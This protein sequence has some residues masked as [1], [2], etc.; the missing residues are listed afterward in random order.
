M[1]IGITAG[2]ISLVTFPIEF[3]LKPYVMLE[4]Q[5][6]S[7]CMN[8]PISYKTFWGVD[9]ALQ[10]HKIRLNYYISSSEFTLGGLL[11][12]PKQ[13]TYYKLLSKTPFEC[14]F[15]QG[16]ISETLTEISTL[17]LK[18]FIGGNQ[19]PSS[20]QYRLRFEGEQS[21]IETSLE[22]YAM[23]IFPGE[24]LLSFSIG[25]VPL[26][27]QTISIQAR[28][29][30]ELTLELGN[31]FAK[32]TIDVTLMGTTPN[33][34][35]SI[36]V[37]DQSR[38]LAADFNILP[39]G[40]KRSIFIVPKGTMKVYYLDQDTKL[41]YGPLE[42]NVQS[43]M[44]IEEDIQTRTIKFEI[45]PEREI[46]S[47][48]LLVYQGESLIRKRS[49][50]ES[51]ILSV[52]PGLYYVTVQLGDYKYEPLIQVNLVDYQ[53]QTVTF[54]LSQSFTTLTVQFVPPPLWEYASVSVYS[55]QQ[56]NEIFIDYN[57]TVVGEE[58]N[59]VMQFLAPRGDIRVKV[60]FEGYTQPDPVDL[61]ILTES[62]FVFLNNL[63]PVKRK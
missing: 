20:K 40:T 3:R 47:G 22:D 49:I 62:E 58:T 4:F 30:K 41:S 51:S 25:A 57:F 1:N 28:E 31:N 39:S 23:K 24:Y 60:N 48:F 2:F 37:F 14:T 42:Y 5:S 7:R 34:N 16:C 43:D 44:Y 46:R 56:S 59:P 36:E 33:A 17:L 21:V 55:V 12:Y 9:W 61:Y 11:P 45:Y 52:A 8:P 63:S 6:D 29:N 15:C 38:L 26:L 53:S 35:L 19:L 54:D 27:N 10:F 32:V 18:L 13:L 50:M